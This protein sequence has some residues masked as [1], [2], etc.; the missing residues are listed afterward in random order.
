MKNG[1]MNNERSEFK[2]VEK[3]LLEIY[4]RKNIP[5]KELYIATLKKINKVLKNENVKTRPYD[6]LK[7]PGGIV[8]LRHD[9]P[10]IIIPDL[11]AREDFFINILLYKDST[12]YSNLQK[13]NLNMLQIVCLGDGFHSEGLGAREFWK[14]ALDEYKMS[15]DKHEN[16]DKEMTKSLGLMEMVMEVKSAFPDN[17]NFL[18]GNHEN[19]TN[20]R[21]GGNF[22]FRKY[23]H[24]GAMVAT[25][26]TKFYGKVFLEEYY[27]FEKN[28]PLI[29]IGKNIILSHAEPLKV[30]NRKSIIEYRSNPDVVRGLTWTSNDEAEDG[31][32]KEM[33]K[34]YLDDD[35]NAYYFSG[36]RPVNNLYKL[37]AKGKLV[38]INNSIKNVIAIIKKNKNIDL[39]RDIIKIVKKKL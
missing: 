33:L 32:V 6:S 9:I 5:N 24:E 12:G 20:E 25:Y 30:Y 11:H 19:I 34:Y 27:M 15:Y 36:H 37:R 39:D 23:A 3:R 14:S 1:N 8:L 35:E 38:Q 29:A 18:K 28:L 13:L 21:K 31:S 10:T 2:Q 16:M 22:P 17:F 7:L 4:N 26:I